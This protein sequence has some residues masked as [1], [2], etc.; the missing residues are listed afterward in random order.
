MN[1]KKRLEFLEMKLSPP[2]WKAREQAIFTFRDG[3]TEQLYGY[4][5]FPLVLDDEI[6][7]VD[8]GNE[9]PII[10]LIKVMVEGGTDE[11]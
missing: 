9:S 10:Q 2:E 6:I 3:H 5:A 4:Q 8:G 7:A 1:N 11:S